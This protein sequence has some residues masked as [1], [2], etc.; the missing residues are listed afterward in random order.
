MNIKR[1]VEKLKTEKEENEESEKARIDFA[2]MGAEF[3]R[4]LTLAEKGELP[5]SPPRNPNAP[6]SQARADFDAYIDRMIERIKDI[7]LEPKPILNLCGDP[8]NTEEVRSDV[9][10]EPDMSAD[11]LLNYLRNRY[12]I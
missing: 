9:E 5:V 4:L 7:Q 3:R 10:S 11:E 6:K 1:V 2:D 12:K 8:A